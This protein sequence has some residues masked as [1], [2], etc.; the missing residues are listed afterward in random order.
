VTDAPTRIEMIFLAD[1]D[2][3]KR[4]KVVGGCS[5]TRRHGV[6]HAR[7]SE[8][9]L[10]SIN[11]RRATSRRYCSISMDVFRG[12]TGV[13][14]QLHLQKINLTRPWRVNGSQRPIAIPNVDA[15][16]WIELHDYPATFWSN[17]CSTIRMKVFQRGFQEAR[18]SKPTHLE[19]E[20]FKADKD[21]KK[22]DKLLDMFLKDPAVAKS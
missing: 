3:H 12:I 17:L 18:G 5:K 21:P 2:E 20:Y 1:R 16:W 10:I 4:A 14:S 22:R 8:R 15:G 13:W 9:G 11:A 7:L 6:R 19:I